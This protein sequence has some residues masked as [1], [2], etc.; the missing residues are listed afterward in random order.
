[1]KLMQKDLLKELPSVSEVLLEVPDEIDLHR[2]Y[3]TFI[4][5]RSIARFRKAARKG[6]LEL[7]RGQIKAEIVAEVA[8]YSRPSLTKVINGTGIVLHTG[9]GRAP[10]HGEILN[11]VARR[12]EGYV[13]LEFDLRTGKRGNRLEHVH[14]IIRAI[15]KAESNLIVNN[16]AAAVLLTLNTL[17]EGREVVVSRGQQVEIGGSFRIPDII[18]KSHCVLK[19]VG[20]TN[21]THLRDYEKAI[22]PDTGLLL[23]VHTSNYIVKGFTKEVP[24]ADLVALGKR[25]RIPVMADLG[26]GALLDLT[27]L[28]LPREIP[29]RELVRTGASVITFSGDKL[30]GGP[31]AGLIIGKKRFIKKI[32]SNPI[33]RAVRCDKMTLAVM[34]EILK[35]YR[36][37]QVSERNLALTLLSTPRS[38]L[39]TRGEEI[40]QAV[41]KEK[42]DI[43]GLS[44]V[45]STV[46]AGSGSLPVEK[47]ESMA[48]RFCPR[49]RKV[50]E[51]AQQF[52]LSAYPVIGYTANNIFYIDLKAILPGQIQQLTETI[53]NI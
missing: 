39:K 3:V 5:K 49:D 8:R 41:S 18:R 46:E 31:Q 22:G 38:I 51:L 29:V 16:N 45:E 50:S 33:Y 32:V 7:S 34:E 47:I 10:I 2:D 28:G 12:L 9:F 23:W 36:S 35:T 42:K 17:A 11:R 1:M 4:I 25:K 53:R 26:S 21:R 44:L 13:N 40:L 27:A 43:L 14:D 30:L 20:T 15:T 19:E 52:R 48:L 37:R 6:A 24:L